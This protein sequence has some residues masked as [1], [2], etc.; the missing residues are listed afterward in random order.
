[1]IYLAFVLCVIGAM[2]SVFAGLEWLICVWVAQRHAKRGKSRFHLG[3][4]IDLWAMVD[5]F[6]WAW[7]V[8]VLVEDLFLKHHHCFLIIK[9]FF[10][11][12]LMDQRW[13]PLI[14]DFTNWQ[15]SFLGKCQ[16]DTSQQNVSIESHACLVI[17]LMCEWW[18]HEKWRVIKVTILPHFYL[19]GRCK[20]SLKFLNRSIFY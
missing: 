13:H 11:K 16:L 14:F 5:W 18:W 9:S 8:L 10:C 12:S 3:N 7:E 20:K 19:F 2:M 1:M 15:P 4:L 17:L 6:C